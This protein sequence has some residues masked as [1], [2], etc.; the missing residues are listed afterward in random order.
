LYEQRRRE[1]DADRTALRAADGHSDPLRALPPPQ[2]P[3]L[4][5]PLAAPAAPDAFGAAL[6]GVGVT[7]NLRRFLS[8]PTDPQCRV[9]HN[10]L[11]RSAP[12]CCAVTLSL[13]VAL[14]LWIRKRTD[15]ALPAGSWSAAHAMFGSRPEQLRWK[16]DAVRACAAHAGLRLVRGGH[17]LVASW[18]LR[19]L[20]ECIVVPCAVPLPVPPPVPPPAPPL[21]LPLPGGDGGGGDGDAAGDAAGGAA[22]GAAVAAGALVPMVA[23]LQG[24]VQV[25]RSSPP[26]WTLP[27]GTAVEC[28]CSLEDEKE[29]IYDGSTL[30]AG[31]HDGQVSG[32]SFEPGPW[33]WIA[34]RRVWVR[35]SC[36]ATPT[37]PHMHTLHMH[38]SHARLT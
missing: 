27:D 29:R 20:P 3:P 21:A 31:L 23:D 6:G 10:T 26:R 25:V 9:L 28:V 32:A 12:H 13:R 4:A 36:C 15:E 22:G 1:C 17:E 11:A 16:L 33:T 7:S 2:L 18:M 38:T 34:S 5:S 30:V 35:T 8:A 19:E 37:G 24:E 14:A